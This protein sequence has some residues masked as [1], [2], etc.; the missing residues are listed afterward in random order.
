MSGDTEVEPP[1]EIVYAALWAGD[2]TVD[3]DAGCYLSQPVNT[4]PVI[5]K[6]AE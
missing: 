6:S 4:R 1:V 2:W 5:S 3:C